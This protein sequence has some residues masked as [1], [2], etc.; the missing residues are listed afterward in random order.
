MEDSKDILHILAKVLGSHDEREASIFFMGS[1][2]RASKDRSFI[3]GLS[4]I[5]MLVVPS[6]DSVDGYEKWL[7]LVQRLSQELNYSRGQLFD[8]FLLSERVVGLHFGCLATLAGALPKKSAQ[9]SKG[10]QVYGLKKTY[11]NADVRIKMYQAMAANMIRDAQSILPA[12][13]TA[14]ARKTLKFVRKLLKA[15]I[16]SYTNASDLD[17][18]E[19]QLI[20]ICEFTSLKSLVDEHVVD[21]IPLEDIFQ[22][23]LDGDKVKDWPQWMTAQEHLLYWLNDID[24]PI[25]NTKD[26]RLYDTITQIVHMLMLDLK[27]VLGEPNEAKRSEKISDFGDKTASMVVRLALAGVDLLLDL[28]TSSTPLRV[29]QGYGIL[30]NHLKSSSQASV[31]CLAA[32]IILLEYALECSVLKEAT[33]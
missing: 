30:V 23:V 17:R 8:V 28:T 19:E 2:S 6:C 3:E 27:A 11:I 18:V 5:D 31:E 22:E 15:I 10:S 25:L 33:E 29:R 1:I 13:D 7:N 32:S 16:C 24:I 26:A 12:A 14:Q 21:K 9:I 20:D 4:D